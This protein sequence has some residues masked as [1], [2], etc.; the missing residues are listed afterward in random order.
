MSD[1]PRNLHDEVV[2]R[3]GNR[4]EYCRLSQLGQEAT[5]HID[6][7]IPR[8]AGGPTMASNL[9]LAGVSCSL[10]K[11]AN[12]TATDPDNGEEVPLFN[13]RIQVWAEHFRWDG[14]RAVPLTATGR[15]TVVALAMNR[16]ILIAI[17]QEESARGRHPPG[18]EIKGVGDGYQA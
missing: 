1:I 8:A 9:A 12:Q 11:W 14:V 5:F 4:C 17:R 18:G 6:H 10:R 15:A 3:A 13:P 7:V 16:P 2:L